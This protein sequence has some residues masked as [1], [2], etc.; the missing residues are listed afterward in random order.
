MG[1]RRIRA[2][3]HRCASRTFT[4]SRVQNQD[5]QRTRTGRHEGV[6]GV[7]RATQ[8]LGLDGGIPAH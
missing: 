3:T 5:R 1:F 4:G 2:Q 8:F 7:P 6:A